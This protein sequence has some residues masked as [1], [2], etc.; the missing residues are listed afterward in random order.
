MEKRLQ[1][2]CLIVRVYVHTHIDRQ[3]NNTNPLPAEVYIRTKDGPGFTLCISWDV[4]FVTL[5]VELRV[6]DDR[7]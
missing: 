3:R 7:L 2:C 6:T 4:V 5:F 1:I